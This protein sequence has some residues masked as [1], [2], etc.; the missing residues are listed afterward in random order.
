ML[1]CSAFFSKIRLKNN[2][3]VFDE[4]LYHGLC[5]FNCSYCIRRDFGKCSKLGRTYPSVVSPAFSL[6]HCYLFW[7]DADVW[8]AACDRICDL[9]GKI[10]G[11]NSF[12]YLEGV[13][14]YNWNRRNFC[15]Y[16]FDTMVDRNCKFD[17]L[18]FSNYFCQ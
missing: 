10:R 11:R 15:C 3:E 9:L 2:G 13:S 17:N 5:S 4:E 1:N 18:R 16:Q 6:L 14:D 7:C 12:Q 8:F